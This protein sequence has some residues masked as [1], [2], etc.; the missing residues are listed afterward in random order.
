MP[1]I[2]PK[3]AAAG[4]GRGGCGGDAVISKSVQKVIFWA[5]VTLKNAF[6]EQNTC[7]KSRKVH[8]YIENVF[9]PCHTYR[10]IYAGAGGGLCRLCASPKNVFRIILV[11]FSCF[12]VYSRAFSCSLVGLAKR[13]PPAHLA[14]PRAQGGLWHCFG[15]PGTLGGCFGLGWGTFLLGCP[16]AGFARG[17]SSIGLHVAQS[18]CFER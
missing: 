7:L 2:P 5:N 15:R 9:F 12:C 18:V 6:W 17:R 13:P 8:N 14:H 4:G 16:G 1:H 11:L 10:R 3:N